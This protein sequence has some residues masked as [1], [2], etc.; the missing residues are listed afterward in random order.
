MEQTSKKNS[1]TLTI[2]LCWLAYTV[3]YLGRYSYSSNILLIEQFYKVTHAQA[4]TVTTMFFFA[5]G[6]G[7]VV[8]GILSKYYDKRLIVSL[9]LI[10]SSICTSLASSLALLILLLTIGIDIKIIKPNI[11]TTAN[12]STNENPFFILSPIINYIIKKR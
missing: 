11:T 5:Y 12:N 9:A 8:H 7:Q 2:F 1:T 4:G 6:I 10:I 3:A